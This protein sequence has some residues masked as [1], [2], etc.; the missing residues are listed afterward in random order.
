MGEV[1]RTLF[2]LFC[3]FAIVF[4]TILFSMESGRFTCGLLVKLYFLALFIQN[5]VDKGH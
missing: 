4:G 2:A 3:V 5:V 1:G